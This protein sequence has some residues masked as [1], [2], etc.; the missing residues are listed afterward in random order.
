MGILENNLQNITLE[1]VEAPKTS[2]KQFKRTFKPTKATDFIKEELKN[3]RLG[4]LGELFVVEKERNFLIKS[5]KE[6]L[7]NKIEHSSLVKGDGL[8]YDILS[9]DIDGNEKYIEVKTT[10]SNIS[11]PFFI[12]INEIE[13]SKTKSNNYF[14]YRIFDFD[15]NLNL[16]KYYIINGNLIEKVNLQATQYLAYPI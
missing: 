4:H 5:G 13:F 10:R 6:S 16:G 2:N 7:A 15:T 14:L 11:R 8:G 12:T 9:Y 1:L 3:R